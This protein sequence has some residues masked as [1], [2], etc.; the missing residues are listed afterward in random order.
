[1][2]KT[3]AVC[4]LAVASLSQYCGDFGPAGFSGVSG[5]D[6]GQLNRLNRIQ[7]NKLVRMDNAVDRAIGHGNWGLKNQ[8]KNQ[9][10][11]QDWS[12]EEVRSQR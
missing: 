10:L 1:M 4:A 11:G 5:R 9:L 12:L 3:I 6:L 2:F 7:N 8:L